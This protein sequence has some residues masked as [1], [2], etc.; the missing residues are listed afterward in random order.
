M[1]LDLLDEPRH[2]GVRVDEES[3]RL[4]TYDPIITAPAVQ[5][6]ALGALLLLRRLLPTVALT[7]AWPFRLSPGMVGATRSSIGS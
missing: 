4:E 6:L 2:S 5:I 7:R 1:P 3:L